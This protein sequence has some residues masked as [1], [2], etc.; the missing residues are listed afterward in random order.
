MI[1]CTVEEVCLAT[2]G[3]VL[4]MGD[5]TVAG[6]TTNSREVHP[7]E[8]FIPLVGERFDGH[9]FIEMALDAGAMGCLTQREPA[10]L[11]PGKTY[12]LVADTL[13]ALKTLA[14]WYRDK[15]DL[16]YHF[17]FEDK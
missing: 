4:Q 6:V 7:G 14:G 11:L 1:P 10:S 16:P 2:G 13:L 9:D 5:G 3:T 17:I 12:I 15:F 8:L